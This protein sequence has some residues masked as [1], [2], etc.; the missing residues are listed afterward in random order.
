[1]SKRNRERRIRTARLIELINNG[2]KPE[3]RRTESAHRFLSLA[4][5]A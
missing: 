4:F 3:N 2:R 5:G 1:M